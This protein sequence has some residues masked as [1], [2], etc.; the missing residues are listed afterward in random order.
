MVLL[1]RLVSRLLATL[2]LAAVALAG[3]AAAVF[4]IQSGHGTLSLPA[5]ARDLHLALVRRSVATELA[6]LKA[7]GP[8]AV[9]SALCGVGA[10]AAGVML[11][12]GVLVPARERLVILGEDQEGTLGARRRALAAIAR[13]LAQRPHDVVAA[14]ARVRPRRR[15]LGGVLRLHVRYLGAG[16]SGAPSAPDAQRR[17]LQRALGGHL[18]ELTEGAPLRISL[19]LKPV[20]R[21]VS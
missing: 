14:R 20:R 10:V 3:L 15:G 4:C 11:L 1:A 17:R 5:L 19:K 13:T 21:R 8:V 12:V 7:H 16:D 2:L 6:R 9:V 18:G